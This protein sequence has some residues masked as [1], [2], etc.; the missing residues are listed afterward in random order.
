MNELEETQVQGQLL[1]GNPP[2]GAQPRAEQRPEALDG[3]DMD[4]AE[5]IAILVARELPGGMTNRTMGVRARKKLIVT[6]EG[7]EGMIRE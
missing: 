7:G 5:T 6:N 4:F 1:L 2:V 3:V